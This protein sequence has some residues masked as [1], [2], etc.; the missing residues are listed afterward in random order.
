MQ[1]FRAQIRG[2]LEKYV[3]DSSTNVEI[4]IFNYTVRTCIENAIVRKWEN[5]EFVRIYTSKLKT[6]LYNLEHFEDVR[7]KAIEHPESMATMTH[8]EMNPVK[9]Q[10]HIERKQKRDKFLT[11]QNLVATTNLFTCF[12]CKKNECTYYQLQTRSADEPMTTFVT[13]VLCDS[14]WRC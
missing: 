7:M 1:S 10:A 9:W 12:K 4:S 14:H 8:A 11:S 5:P 13:C 2:Q 6:I 3:A